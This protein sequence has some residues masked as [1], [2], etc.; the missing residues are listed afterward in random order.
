MSLA[1]LLGNLSLETQIIIAGLVVLFVI[2]ALLHASNL[3]DTRERE[4]AYAD[5]EMRARLDRLMQKLEGRNV[6]A[7]GRIVP[8]VS[9]PRPLSRTADK[10]VPAARCP[11][12]VRSQGGT[13]AR[14]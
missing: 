8:A 12:P 1:E 9:R 11:A 6:G 7:N 3:R 2:L 13:A 4:A 10:R 14:R 5:R